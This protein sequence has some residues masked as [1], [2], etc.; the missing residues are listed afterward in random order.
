MMLCSEVPVMEKVAWFL[1]GF[2]AGWLICG[3]VTR[4]RLRKN[5]R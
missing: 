1:A 2:I 4:R 3:F 5:K